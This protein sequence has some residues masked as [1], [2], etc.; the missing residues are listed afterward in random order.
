M[1]LY[2]LHFMVKMYKS[3]DEL[4]QNWLDL[5]PQIEN[6]IYELLSQEYIDIGH[7][8][9]ANNQL[10]SIYRAKSTELAD[11]VYTGETNIVEMLENVPLEDN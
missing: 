11:G 6:R 9:G 7:H 4:K 1:R 10:E 8:F 2:Y 5:K 3:K